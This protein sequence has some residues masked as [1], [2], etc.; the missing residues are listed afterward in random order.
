M[1]SR[2]INKN[3]G[4]LS[5]LHRLDPRTKILL[6]LLF[7][8]LI[9]A[10]SRPL[11]A[12][13]FTAGLSALWLAAK[14]PF[15]K[16][17]TVI[18]FLPFMVLFITLLQMLFGPG[19]HYIL[20]PL[21]PQGVPFIGGMGSLK[22][23]GLILGMTSG[24]RLLSLVLLLPLLTGTSS[25]HELAQGFTGLRLNYRA[26][27]VIS[28]AINLVPV[29]EEEARNII[30]AQKLRGLRVFD[31]GNLWKKLKAYPA[32]TVPLIISAMRRSQSMAYAMDSRA[33]GAYPRRTWLAPLGMKAC[34]YLALII[35]VIFCSL[36]LYLNF[37]I[38]KI[39]LVWPFL[40]GS[41][42]WDFLCQ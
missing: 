39:A 19:A 7:T 30:N 29:L 27:F 18:R 13:I 24:L 35:S 1:K 6:S 31:E 33:F 12:A 10:V 28:S 41:A 8:L 38:E 21:I 16:I 42:L 34:D 25:L 4:G 40:S 9:F 20:K 3:T 15:K 17:I 14:I 22:W 2:S 23:E 5:F 37:S 11:A 36:V 26:A 32:L